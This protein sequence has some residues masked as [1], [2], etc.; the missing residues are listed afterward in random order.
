MRPRDF[1]SE[2]GYNCRFMK[3]LVPTDRT[4]PP[5]ESAKTVAMQAF[6]RSARNCAR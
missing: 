5:S 1:E 4:N 3:R 6:A 2:T